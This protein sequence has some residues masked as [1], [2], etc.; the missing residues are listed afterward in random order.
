MK[1]DTA[2]TAP[3]T[4]VENLLA[5]ILGIATGLLIGYSL[6]KTAELVSVR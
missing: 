3:T 1:S 2:A 5:F 4:N 6:L